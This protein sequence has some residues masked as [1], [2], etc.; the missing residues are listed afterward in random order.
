MIIVTPISVLQVWLYEVLPQHRPVQELVRAAYNQLSPNCTTG[1]WLCGEKREREE[2]VTVPTKPVT[3]ATPTH[4][5]R[6]TG[7]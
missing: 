2:G 5:A 6:F 4:C 3:A 1:G 7:H